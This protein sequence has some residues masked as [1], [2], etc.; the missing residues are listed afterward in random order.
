MTFQKGH[1]LL[2]VTLC[3]SVHGEYA[4]ADSAHSCGSDC[5]PSR[6]QPA[7][8]V[9]PSFVTGPKFLNKELKKWAFKSCFSPSLV[10]SAMDEED[11]KLKFALIQDLFSTQMEVFDVASTG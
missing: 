7:S 9:L 5:P 10:S 11:L 6:S 4:G 1:L 2:A 3:C 8:A